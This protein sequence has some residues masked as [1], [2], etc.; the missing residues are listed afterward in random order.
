MVVPRIRSAPARL[1]LG[2]AVIAGL[3]ILLSD[4]LV[5][6]P[7]WPA[8]IQTAKGW[9]F[10]L[11]TAIGLYVLMHRLMTQVSRLNRQLERRAEQLETRVEERTREL[12]QSQ[13]ELDAFVSAASHD[14]RA[15]I[16]SIAGF[17]EALGEDFRPVLGAEGMGHVQRILGAAERMDTIVADLQEYNRLAR[18]NLALAPVALA[19]LLES[20][21]ELFAPQLEATGG[22]I[23]LVPPLP[24]VQ[25][26]A[27]TLGRVVMNLFDNALKFVDRGVAPRVTVRA[28]GRGRWVRVWVEDEGIGLPA[29]RLESIFDPFER[30][31]SSATYP[32]TGFGLAVVRR[33]V[34]RMGGTVGVQSTPGRGSRFWFELPS[35]DGDTAVPGPAPGAA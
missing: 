5:L 23:E 19:D 12:A 24:R 33:G 1:A 14:L 28:E 18:S 21:R 26:H 10:V 2:Y 22:T 4:R 35:A 17:A 25:G 34:E 30:L 15:P 20:T 16:R 6:K 3:W 8:W 13:R 32:G 9:L 11:V 27:E 29:G 7:G 31:H